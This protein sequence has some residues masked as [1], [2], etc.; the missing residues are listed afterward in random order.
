MTGI[1]KIAFKSIRYYWKQA[2]YQF[3]ITI[4]LCAVITGSLLTGYSVRSSLKNTASEH[5]GNT[6]ILVSSGLRYFDRDLALKLRDSA[7]IDCAGILEIRG[8]SQAMAS[9]KSQNNSIIYAVQDDFFM[10]HGDTAAVGQGQ[11]LINAKLASYLGIGDGDEIIIRFDEIT[12]IP[13]DAP[14]APEGSEAASMVL[15]AA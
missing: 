14:F 7:K 15:K 1:L 8:S 12:G 2:L 11:A 5:L 10:F 6:G 9:Q 3:L 4:I 13:A